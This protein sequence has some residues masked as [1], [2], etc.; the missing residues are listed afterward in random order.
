M[1]RAELRGEK[2]NE[3]R[4]VIS[5]SGFQTQAPPTGNSQ[6]QGD[7]P[8]AIPSPPWTQGSLFFRHC[9]QG[10][11]PARLHSS[12][13]PAPQTEGRDRVGEG[14]RQDRRFTF[15]ASASRQVITHPVM[16]T[17]IQSDSGPHPLRAA[18]PACPQIRACPGAPTAWTGQHVERGYP[19]LLYH[20]STPCC[21]ASTCPE[22]SP[23]SQVLFPVRQNHLEEGKWAVPKTIP[24]PG[25]EHKGTEN[26]GRSPET[27][28][29]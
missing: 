15:T 21:A 16:K 17:R 29:V 27:S 4:S 11:V 3:L 22:I 23:E 10:R 6:Q 13:S 19:T 1:W 2:G 12:C 5:S 24:D 14:D 25:T 9:Q 18:G 7:G 20:C 26:P 28:S 8:L